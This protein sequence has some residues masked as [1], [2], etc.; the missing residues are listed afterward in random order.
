[1]EK[2]AVQQQKKGRG[3]NRPEQEAMGEENEQGRR[4]G[5]AWEASILV[6]GRVGYLKMDESY[7]EKWIYF[8]KTG[9]F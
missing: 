7:G 4:G 6:P 2:R 1:M 8:N 3:G 5:R 9:L